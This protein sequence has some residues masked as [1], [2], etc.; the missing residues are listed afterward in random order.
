MNA[1]PWSLFFLLLGAGLLGSLAVIPYTLSINPAGI[2]QLREKLAAKNSKLPAA[3]VVWLSS[4][5]NSGV[6]IA[7]AAFVGL[8]AA[9]AIGLKL[10]FLQALAAGQ[11]APGSF[12]P[13]LPIAAI[14]GFLGGALLIGMEF[15]Y[16]FP[17]LPASMKA[18]ERETPLWKAALACFYGGFVEE[19]LMRLF[20]MAGLAWLIGLLWKIPAG[21]PTLG[22]FWAANILATVLFGLGHLPATARITPL[23]P[24]IIFRAVLLNGFVG[25]IFGWLFMTYGL[26]AAMVAHFSADIVVHMISRAIKPVAYRQAEMQVAQS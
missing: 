6:L 14:A 26:E 18:A 7:I 3:A 24:F 4:T 17:R 21:T 15:F 8:L 11:P 20:M 19:I 10:D 12:L 2:D 16:F 23:T 9:R 22:A 13:I 1:Y 5:L 25:L